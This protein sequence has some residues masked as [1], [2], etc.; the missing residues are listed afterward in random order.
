MQARAL[1]SI[2]PAEVHVAGQVRGSSVALAQPATV[3]IGVL[4]AAVAVGDV[5]AYA[6]DVV[7]REVGVVDDVLEHVPVDVRGQLVR[8]VP[9]VGHVPA[10]VA[11]LAPGGNELRVELGRAV[12]DA[13]GRDREHWLVAGVV[14]SGCGYTVHA[15]GQKD[16]GQE[17][18]CSHGL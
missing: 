3:T 14:G 5:E 9:D 18:E 10:V 7:D 17:H 4:L 6:V 12:V 1:L 11:R 2:E 8:G 15:A 13:F 16:Q